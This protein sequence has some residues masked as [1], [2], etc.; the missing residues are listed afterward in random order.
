MSGRVWNPYVGK[1]AEGMRASAQIDREEADT[2]DSG[3]PRRE[4][5]LARADEWERRAFEF[6]RHRCKVRSSS[7]GWWVDCE[8]CGGFG[9]FEDLEGDAIALAARHQEIGGFER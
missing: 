1:G 9:Q 5:L 2:L 3:D 4:E 8:V 7:D 6:D